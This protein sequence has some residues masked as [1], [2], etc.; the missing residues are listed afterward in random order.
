VVVAVLIVDLIIASGFIPVPVT[1]VKTPTPIATPDFL[2]F[3][4]SEELLVASASLVLY[5]LL[6]VPAKPVSASS[7]AVQDLDPAPS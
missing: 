7:T 4:H 6:L 5:P 3:N 1:I 2:T